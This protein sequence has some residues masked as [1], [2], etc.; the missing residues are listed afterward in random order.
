MKVNLLQGTYIP[1]L[2][3]VPGV[4]KPLQPTLATSAF[5]QARDRA[6]WPARLNGKRSAA[7]IHE[8]MP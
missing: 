3:P 6:L 7:L 8:R 1:T 5:G 4:H 2:T